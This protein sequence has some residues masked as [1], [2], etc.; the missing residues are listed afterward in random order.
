MQRAL[1]VQALP[2]ALPV[3]LVR[4]SNGKLRWL[5]DL[6][7]CADINPE[8]WDSAKA[9]PRSDIGAAPSDE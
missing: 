3:Q 9:F 5:L 1:E 7:A 8:L 4:P 6:E 2:G